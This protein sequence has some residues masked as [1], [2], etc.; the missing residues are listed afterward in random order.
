MPQASIA[1]KTS[2]D[3][4]QNIPIS[5]SFANKD[6]WNEKLVAARERV[7]KAKREYADLVAAR[8]PLEDHL[9][10]SA[11]I[12]SLSAWA[13]ALDDAADDVALKRNLIEAM[14]YRVRCVDHGKF[15]ID[16]ALDTVSGKNKIGIASNVEV[17]P[18]GGEW[19]RSQ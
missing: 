9:K 1:G 11:V 7:E 13:K 19:W 16:L 4:M 12:Q 17:M 15:E 6:Y 2:I 14:V 3:T 18:N 5:I 10:V 8:E